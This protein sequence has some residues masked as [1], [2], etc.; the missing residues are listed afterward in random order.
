MSAHYKK[1]S[2]IQ[3]LS[4]HNPFSIVLPQVLIELCFPETKIKRDSSLIPKTHFT[5]TVNLKITFPLFICKM[6]Q[7][8]NLQS[9]YR[10]DRNSNQ[11]MLHRIPTYSKKINIILNVSQF[12]CFSIYQSAGP[13]NTW[14]W[15]MIIPPGIPYDIIPLSQTNPVVLY[16]EVTES[17]NHSRTRENQ[18]VV[19]RPSSI[20]LSGTCIILMH[21]YTQS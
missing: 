2:L 3:L 1:I 15:Y 4:G 17:W 13:I 19:V 6:K 18:T 11:Y 14:Y 5:T 12:Q 21:Q 8:V 10:K 20:V 7:I 16:M 9:T